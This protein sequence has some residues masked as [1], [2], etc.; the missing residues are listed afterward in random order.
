[1]RIVQFPDGFVSAAAPQ[2]TGSSTQENFIIENGLTESFFTI[3]SSLFKSAFFDYEIEREDSNGSFRQVG[4]F[5]MHF[6]GI[7]WKLEFGNFQ[8]SELIT[9]T[10][11]NE[12]DILLNVSTT[13]G[14]GSL[15]Y[16]S[17]YML[18]LAYS[19]KIKLLITRV[20][21]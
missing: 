9:D 8:G 12:Q 11:V 6:D 1:M 20:I 19:G 5:I 2:I 13:L 7:D 10:I 3:D 14:V 4:S 17:G 16:T 15:E 18:G 21:L